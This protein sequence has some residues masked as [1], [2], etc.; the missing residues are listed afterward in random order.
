MS[1]FNMQTV[2]LQLDGQIGVQCLNTLLHSAIAAMAQTVGGC[3]AVRPQCVPSKLG[4]V[5][6]RPG[7]V[8]C[9][10]TRLSRSLPAIL[11]RGDINTWLL[12]LLQQSC[13][14]VVAQTT[15]STIPHCTNL[16]ST[17]MHVLRH[18]I[19]CSTH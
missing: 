13:W 10:F 4:Q 3:G 2:S 1:K 14:Y 19:L 18:W 9:T 15:T 11:G 17:C 12:P 16:I 7:Y 5:G 6:F 8:A